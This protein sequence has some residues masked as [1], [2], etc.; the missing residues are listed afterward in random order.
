MSSF[1]YLQFL[2]V[3]KHGDGSLSFP[4]PLGFS[5]SLKLCQPY[6]YKAPRRVSTKV[7]RL[8][9]PG[10]WAQASHQ[11]E[12]SR[13]GEIL[14]ECTSVGW[15]PGPKYSGELT[16]EKKF[17]SCQSRTPDEEGLFTVRLQ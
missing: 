6:S 1:G 16:R 2:C 8:L 14:L 12:S 4:V 7:R 9:S 15:H 3:V 10:L 5:F 17:P 13:G 11:Y